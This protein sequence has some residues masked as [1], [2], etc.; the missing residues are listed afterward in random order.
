MLSGCG[1]HEH[2]FY[3]QKCGGRINRAEVELWGDYC[4][5]DTISNLCTCVCA[6]PCQQVPP[7]DLK[8]HV[9]WS[10]GGCLLATAE[11]AGRQADGHLRRKVRQGDECIL[12]LVGGG[13][14]GEHFPKVST[15]RQRDEVCRWL[16][17]EFLVNGLVMVL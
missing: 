9:L 7:C 15:L 8:L 2:H 3:R 12:P 4:R 1:N 11:K 10:L 6:R 16:V 17:G 13:Y 14:P 5:G